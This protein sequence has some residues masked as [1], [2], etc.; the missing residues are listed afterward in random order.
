[1]G[2][3]LGLTMKEDRLKVIRKIF[4]LRMGGSKMG[5]DKTA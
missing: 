5:L 4:G 1:M 3:K 2:V